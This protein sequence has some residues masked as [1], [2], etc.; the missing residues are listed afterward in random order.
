MTVGVRGA[1]LGLRST[2]SVPRNHQA[3]PVP[4]SVERARSTVRS[5]RLARP[6]EVFMSLLLWNDLAKTGVAGTMSGSS[7]SL[8]ECIDAPADGRLG[9]GIAQTAFIGNAHP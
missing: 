7:K 1:P 9:I 4:G 8:D 2:A 6:A 3:R 5:S